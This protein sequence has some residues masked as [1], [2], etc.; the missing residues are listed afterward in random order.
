MRRRTWVSSS[1]WAS[2]LALRRTCFD[3]D[4]DVRWVWTVY[5]VLPSAFDRFARCV[6]DVREAGRVAHV[7]FHHARVVQS[8][9]HQHETSDVTKPSWN[10]GRRH[11][12][13]GTTS[14]EASVAIRPAPG[15]PEKAG[16]RR[17]STVR[18]NERRTCR[19]KQIRS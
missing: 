16:K 6:C 11:P 15:S 3:R 14:L 7:D 4:D 12:R 13:R 8:V 1:L 18:G 5:V 9:S 10:V 17:A 19:R 2:S